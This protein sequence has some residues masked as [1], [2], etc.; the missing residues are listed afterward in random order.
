VILPVRLRLT[1]WYVTLLAV[2]LP[3]PLLFHP[4]FLHAVV[5]PLLK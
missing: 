1:A 5:I 2:I 3:L 4:P